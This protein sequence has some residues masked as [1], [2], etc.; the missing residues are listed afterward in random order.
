MLTYS[1]YNY[2]PR[3]RRQAESLRDANHSVEVFALRGEGEPAREQVRNITVIRMPAKKHRESM[4]AYIFGY[5]GF[6]VI[7]TLYITL[8]YM[9]NHYDLI[10]IYN[11]PDFL[12]FC[13]M[14]PKLTGAKLVLDVRDPMLELLRT[15]F[16]SRMRPLIEQLV[17]IQERLSYRIPD[18]IVTVNSAM[19]ETLLARGV[20]PAKLKVIHNLPDSTLFSRSD[21]DKGNDGFSLVYTGTISARHCIDFA[22]EAL[23]I[24]KDRIPEIFLRI[25]GEGPDI[26]R[27]Q[28][29]IKK[30][31]L[32]DKVILEGLIPLE[33]IPN[34]L[35]GCNVGIS[36]YAD[37][38][39]AALVL[40]TKIFEYLMVGLPVVCSRTPTLDKY[41]DESMVFYF[42]PADIKS[43]IDQVCLI[44]DA[45]NLVVEKMRSA[46]RLLS[47]MNWQYEKGIFQ[48]TIN[49]IL[50]RR[51]LHDD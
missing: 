48:T 9:I 28:E 38:P 8:Y 3:V 35:S 13:G 31:H 1:Y 29:I 18:L 21:T 6:F 27:L 40:P 32:E 14:I 22:I 4:F 12:V 16:G 43:F 50:T 30:K 42:N 39:F 10:Y 46:D 20:D 47:K 7:S 23:Y 2:D 19:L 15:I 24:L 49:R 36:T 5:L 17:K 34:L 33:K 11:M 26:P 44:H 51:S 37:D 41:V 25:V 45:P